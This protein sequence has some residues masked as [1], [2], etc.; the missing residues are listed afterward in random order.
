MSPSDALSSVGIIRVA[1]G[2]V[3]VDKLIRTLWKPVRAHFRIWPLSLGFAGRG[4]P[5]P[6]VHPPDSWSLWTPVQVA[7]LTIIA[8]RFPF[9]HLCPLPKTYLCRLRCASLLKGVVSCLAGWL[10]CVLALLCPAAFPSSWP[11]LHCA[12]FPYFCPF[13][14]LAGGR[15]P[16]CWLCCCGMMAGGSGLCWWESLQPRQLEGRQRAGSGRASPLQLVLANCGRWMCGAVAV[17]GFWEHYS[18]SGHELCSPASPCQMPWDKGGWK[19]C[20]LACV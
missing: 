18:K 3:T 13:S 11:H 10:G 5:F 2:W 14:P 12:W 16:H 19:S 20:V 17:T 7:W 1:V 8:Q 9:F 4:S 6:H 15:V